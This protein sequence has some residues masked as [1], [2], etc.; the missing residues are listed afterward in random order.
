M[1]NFNLQPLSEDELN[2]L[3]PVER[4]SAEMQTA[5]RAGNEAKLEQFASNIPWV[6]KPAAQLFNALG[7]RG[8]S[9]P[10]N[11]I[12]G[13]INGL[14]KLGNAVGDWAQNKPIDVSDAWQI[15]DEVTRRADMRRY[16]APG[17]NILNGLQYDG[18]VT[19]ADEAGRGIAEGLGG[20]IAGAYAT[21]GLSLLAK[22]TGLV[23]QLQKSDQLRRAVTLANSSQRG[24][25]AFKA[26]GYFAETLT[27]TTLA[28]LFM[29]NS[30]GN[31][32]NITQIFDPKAKPLPFGVDQDDDYLEATGKT[33]F[34]E[35]LLAP[36]A[37]FGI[38]MPIAPFRRSIL[39]GDLPTAVQQMVDAE[40]APY[41][42]VAPQN[43][44]PGMQGPQ[45]P[46]GALAVVPP[47]EPGGAIVP[48]D[49][50][51]S[52]GI[53][54][55]LQVQQVTQQRQRLQDMGLVQAGRG[56]QLEL[57]MPGVV[58]P[59]VKMQI[60]QLQ[61]ERGLLIKQGA[62]E[63]AL[64]K[65]DQQIDDLT[66][67][68]SS[69]AERIPP[70]QGELDMPD[71]RPELDTYLAMLDE[72][73]DEQLGRMLENVNGPVKEKQRQAKIE[74]AQLRM[75]DI[76]QRQL[77]TEARLAAGEIT[78]KGA[79]RINNKIKKELD[80]ARAEAD[81]LQ[82][83]ANEPKTFTVGQQLDMNMQGQ[84][85][86]SP[87]AMAPDVELPPIKD[88]EFVELPDGTGMWRAKGTSER[89]SGGYQSVDDYREV[90]MGM[91]RDVLRDMARPNM[92]P[93]GTWK[94]SPE[95]S[96][97]LKAQ[98]GRRVDR[99]KK[100][101]IVNALVELAQKRGRFVDLQLDMKLPQQGDLAL[102]DTTVG[103]EY[104]MLPKSE[105][106]KAA[107][108][109]A[110]KKEL[111]QMAINNGEVQA[112]VTPLPNRPTVDYDQMGLIDDLLSDENGQFA[113]DY[114]T[115]AVP[116]YRAGKKSTEAMLEEIRLRLDFGRLD[117]DALQMQN[118]AVL[119]AMNWDQMTWAQ[120]QESGLLDPSQ[121][122]YRGQAL[123]FGTERLGFQRKTE[124][125]W[126]KGGPEQE[127]AARLAANKP[128]VQRPGSKKV[129]PPKAKRAKEPEVVRYQMVK[130]EIIADPA[131][132]PPKQPKLV[133]PETQT[134]LTDNPLDLLENQ[135]KAF[136]DRVVKQTMDEKRATMQS[137]KSNLQDLEAEIA[138]L[139]NQQIGRSC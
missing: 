134:G 72:M 13:P 55:N 12:A 27:S 132:A 108:R 92:Q 66:M 75:Q 36:L 35:G 7:S 81:R 115:D 69:N 44:L 34:G 23:R 130:G 8:A 102:F 101:D 46:G 24:R 88:F 128:V 52:R 71:G 80:A 126:V 121:Y 61:T 10:G 106:N 96:A 40:I 50:A 73:S 18:G 45:E 95:A 138:E 93:D 57:T 6:G 1:P 100:V 120:K 131:I 39:N 25:Q 47:P 28:T 62:D 74:E 68:G 59:G 122:S 67:Q 136:Q 133:N 78:P 38:A 127:A 53:D 76:E 15:P 42:A 124:V 64:S 105:M 41:G 30:E 16:T 21:G 70:Q 83:D 22:G 51:I 33:V 82:A 99:A 85:D 4:N 123:E 11:F 103:G 84:L 26:G 3:Q 125:N 37:I 79:T 137:R 14:S 116:T 31:L 17:G 56:N 63:G 135:P 110:I 43:R 139:E 98:T 32:G 107:A 54:E 118:R 129:T 112:P 119:D 60:R 91:G 97:V 104:S 5:A 86:F 94:G 20:E 65:I 114:A 77:N 109:E 9:N 117:G 19:P 113:L 49:S 87:Q 90:L 29:D 89:M 48:Y 2:G 111:L 58:D